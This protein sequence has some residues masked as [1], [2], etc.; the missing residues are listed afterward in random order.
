MGWPDMGSN[1]SSASTKRVEMLSVSIVCTT[2]WTT[3][4][5][6]TAAGDDI[7]IA[8]KKIISCW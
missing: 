5:V 4:G 1:L 7:Y 6:G 2:K 8:V 3:W